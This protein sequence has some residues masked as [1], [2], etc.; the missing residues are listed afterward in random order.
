MF[1]QRIHALSLIDGS[2]KLETYGDCGTVNA[3]LQRIQK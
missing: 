1:T 3:I 2:E